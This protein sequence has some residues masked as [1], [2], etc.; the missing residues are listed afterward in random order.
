[1][2]TRRESGSEIAQQSTE[3][4]KETG[5]VYGHR[6][7][8]SW[9]LEYQCVWRRLG[10]QRERSTSVFPVAE[11]KHRLLEDVLRGEEDVLPVLNPSVRS[12]RM[13]QSGRE[14]DRLPGEGDEN[15]TAQRNQT[16]YQVGCPSPRVGNPTSWLSMHS[17][18]SPVVAA[19]GLLVLECMIRLGE[20]LRKRV[21]EFRRD[22]DCRALRRGGCALSQTVG[23]GKSG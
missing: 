9:S 13:N 2:L 21:L 7:Y 5:P 3:R 10:N 18:S 4:S 14:S 16:P 22:P 17:S 23:E 12:L 6:V 8:G 15:P 20:T 11:S 19:I 1:M